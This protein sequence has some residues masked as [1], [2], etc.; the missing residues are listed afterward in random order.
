MTVDL[1]VVWGVNSTY[2]SRAHIVPRGLKAGLCTLPT[3][4]ERER[5]PHGYRI[6]PE[7]AIAWVAVIFPAARPEHVSSPERRPQ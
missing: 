4:D 5:R 2:S 3:D 7:C 1:E 6:C